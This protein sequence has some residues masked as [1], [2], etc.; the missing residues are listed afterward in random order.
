VAAVRL[1]VV[2][3]VLFDATLVFGSKCAPANFDC[4]AETLLNTVCTEEKLSKGLVHRQFDDV[5]VALAKGTKFAERFAAKYEDVCKT[6]RFP[7][8]KRVPTTKKQI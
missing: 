8:Q 3:T 2:G 4:L 6:A 5:P 7:L 1:Q